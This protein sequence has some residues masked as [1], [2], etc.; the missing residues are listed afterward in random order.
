M[1]L[2]Y[3]VMRRHEKDGIATLLPLQHLAA[4]WIATIVVVWESTWQLDA[5]LFGWPW[6]AAACGLI[7]AAALA[8]ISRFN[9][10]ASWPFGTHYA[11][12]YR[13]WGLGPIAV[14]LVLWMFYANVSEPG[15]MQPLPYL[16]LLNPLDIASLAVLAA[17]W[18][19]SQTFESTH[20]LG[21]NAVKI[22]VGLAFLW[23]NCVLLRTIHYW[24]DV[25]Y[26]WQALSRSVVVQSGFSLLW[27]A[28]AFVLM[29]YATRRGR[30]PLW[31]IGAVLLGVVVL[32]LFLNDLSSTGTIARIVSFLGVG[33]G[34]LAIGYVAPVPPGDREL[35]G[36]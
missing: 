31:I 3:L 22:L 5:L 14:W 4:L 34:L 29:L 23:V 6:R 2:Q 19:W 11:G 8:A 28:S 18:W 20:D 33:A 35:Q 1:L 12:I 13:E 26:E 24:A 30:R 15:S 17:L 36:D 16:P 27:T 9:S 25:P 7:P 32:K 10:S 21:Q